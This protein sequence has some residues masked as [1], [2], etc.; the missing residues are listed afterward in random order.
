[1]TATCSSNWNHEFRRA[2][3][4]CIESVW[5]SATLFRTNHVKSPRIQNSTYPK[6]LSLTRVQPIQIHLYTALSPSF[7][8]YSFFTKPCTLLLLELLLFNKHST[9]YPNCKLLQSCHFSNIYACLQLF[10]R[11]TMSTQLCVQYNFIIYTIYCII[12]YCN[13]CCTSFKLPAKN[14]TLSACKSTYHSHLLHI[15]CVSKKL[16]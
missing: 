14:T 5:G 7:C 15:R 11:V 12:L 16:D 3:R 6:P 4:L 2:P 1:M 13:I 9:V 10:A 8:T